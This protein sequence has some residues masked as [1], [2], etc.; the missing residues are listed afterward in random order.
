MGIGSCLRFEKAEVRFQKHLDYNPIYPFERLGDSLYC[1]SWRF[2]YLHFGLLGTIVAVLG[3]ILYWLADGEQVCGYRYS[4]IQIATCSS[5]PFP[6]ETKY[7]WLSY[8]RENIKWLALTLKSLN[9]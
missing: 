7:V 3:L 9:H 5:F 1:F 6:M 2:Q 8:S 4:H